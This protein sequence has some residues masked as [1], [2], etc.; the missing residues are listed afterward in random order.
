MAARRLS[1][2]LT[3][4]TSLAVI[5]AL[6]WPLLPSREGE[7]AP[8]APSRSVKQVHAGKLPSDW[9]LRQRAWP[10]EDIDQ[11]ARLSAFR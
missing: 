4:L 6:T 10:D 3:S 1:I 11:D 7:P 5:A 9:F 8:S 2:A